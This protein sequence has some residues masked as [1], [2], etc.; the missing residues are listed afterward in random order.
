M[1]V[2]FYTYK[3]TPIK[4]QTPTFMARPIKV[5]WNSESGKKIE[6]LLIWMGASAMAGITEYKNNKESTAYSGEE[7][8]I[9]EEYIDFD[10]DDFLSINLS[11][12]EK[13]IFFSEL[14]NNELQ[15]FI[16]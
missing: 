1:K 10:D 7:K 12:R 2:D 15:G 8:E 4:Y 3:Q 16:Q 6:Q 13:H 11:G 9:L 14:Y 5:D